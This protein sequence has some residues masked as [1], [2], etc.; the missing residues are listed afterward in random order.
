MLKGVHEMGIVNVLRFDD[1]A[2]AMITD[3]EDNLQVRRNFTRNNLHRLVDPEIA[4]KLDMDAIYGGVGDSSLHYEVCDTV[5]KALNAGFSGKKK[6][7]P[8]KTVE[9]IGRLVIQ[10]LNTVL[11]RKVNDR[12]RY[13]FGF[14]SDDL[15]RG[16]FE[17]GG[18]RYEIKQEMVLKKAIDISTKFEEA[19]PRRGNTEDHAIIM[20][21]DGEHRLSLYNVKAECSVLSYVSGGYDT[22]GSG[23]YASGI[24]FAK[25]ISRKELK[26]RTSGVDHAEGLVELILSSIFASEYC[27]FIGGSFRLVYLNGAVKDPARRVLEFEENRV[28]LGCEIVFAH[29]ADLIG[30]TECI[31]LVRD[32]L[33]DGQSVTRVEKE[34]FR[35][36]RDPVKLDI[37]LRGYKLDLPEPER[38][39]FVPG[40]DR[41]REKT[42]KVAKAGDKK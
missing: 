17:K 5:R 7:S 4:G 30:R 39:G 34:L 13:L 10:S 6:T 31:G 20:G 42:G 25:Y 19:S 41:K 29:H 36:A 26:A 11:K 1:Y 27:T 38:M 33:L 9:D 32:L 22:I 21:F 37:C 3:E 2:G 24:S 18:V 40:T 15:N 16:Y 12:L 23:K 28:K 8:C 35:L 14:T